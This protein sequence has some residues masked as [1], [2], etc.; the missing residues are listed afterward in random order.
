MKEIKHLFG[1]VGLDLRHSFS[2]KY[3][4]QKFLELGL[5]DSEYTLFPID[6]ISEIKNII[7]QNPKLEGLNITSP[8]KEAVIPYL[9]EIDETTAEIGAVNVV[10]INRENKNIHL[11]GFNSDIY[12]IR[13]T[14]ESFD[15]PKNTEA[16]ILG[17]GG[18]GKSI[19]YVL[20]E[21]GI[22]CRNVSRNPK[23]SEQIAYSDLNKEIIDGHKLIINATPQGMFPKVDSFPAIPYEFI[24]PEHYCF[25]LI[26]NPEKTVFLAK[27]KSQGATITNGY[28]MLCRQADKAWEI[29]NNTKISYNGRTD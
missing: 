2:Q 18:S 12:G 22:P 23:N 1:L 27:C 13:A 24:T 5:D 4:N 10:K 26:Y 15:L 14:V 8:Y 3:F 16:L 29:W 20:N 7:A 9:D 21:I 28:K 17:S 11:K 25:D 6:D 19:R